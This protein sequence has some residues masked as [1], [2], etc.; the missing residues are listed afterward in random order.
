MLAVRF[1]C[2][3]V[4]YFTLLSVDAHTVN[5]R[6]WETKEKVPVYYVYL[7]ALP[8]VDIELLFH[9]GSAKDGDEPGLAFF[10]AQMLGHGATKKWTA[11]EILDRFDTVGGI[12]S[13]TASRDANVLQLRSLTDPRYFSKNLETFLSIVQG[14]AFLEKDIRLQRAQI[15]QS[16]QQN[17]QMP[18]QIAENAFFSALYGKMP[19]GHAVMGNTDS[20]KRI[21]AAE[22]RS[23][24]QHYYA[25][26]QASIVI[27]GALAPSD[28]KKVAADCA[29]L[30][31][32]NTTSIASQA[33]KNEKNTMALSPSARKITK[34]I[35]YPSSQT[36]IKMGTFGISRHDPDYFA[37]ML[38]NHILGAGALTSR[39]F[40]SLRVKHA[41]TYRVNSS[42]LAMESVGP[43]VM[44]LQTRTAVAAPAVKQLK[45][46]LIQFLQTGPTAQE[47][48]AAKK[49]IM[50]SF[51]LGLDSNAA[52]ANIVSQI[53]FYQLP[54]NYLDTYQANVNAVSQEQIVDAFRRHIDANKL[55]TVTVGADQRAGSRG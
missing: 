51:V 23:F 15:L 2:F 26:Q 55:V 27:V 28:A 31:A 1:L 33:K 5:V 52:I 46:E 39:L 17:A 6:Q 3:I 12:F 29:A 25:R 14:P 34:H 47:V 4:C 50:G 19:Y 37:L 32:N 22:L 30:L 24:Y 20:I 7:P 49:N 53:A 38:G 18:D 35:D 42:F 11:E 48:Q 10:T 45:A 54:I 36:Y 44:A 40:Q 9:A 43:F 21:K 8:I 13:S 16:L 41:Y